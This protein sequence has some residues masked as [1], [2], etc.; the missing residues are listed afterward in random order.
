M[1]HGRQ[2]ERYAHHPGW[3]NS[4]SQQLLTGHRTQASV[5]N[6]SLAVSESR[7]EAALLLT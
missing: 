3:L 1:R 6:E 5:K 4:K 2:R 7:K